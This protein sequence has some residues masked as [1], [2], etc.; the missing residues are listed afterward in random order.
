[1]AAATLAGVRTGG[2][3]H[4]YQPISFWVPTSVKSFELK[5]KDFVFRSGDTKLRIT[6]RL[7]GYPRADF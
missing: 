3:Q 6:P 2:T 7:R 5:T 1:M 4:L